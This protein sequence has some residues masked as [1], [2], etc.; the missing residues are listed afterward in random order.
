MIY[1]G[2]IIGG[3]FTLGITMFIRPAKH[4]SEKENRVLQQIPT[5][6]L[7]SFVQGQYQE[8]LEKG[9]DDQFPGRDGL[10]ATASIC[11]RMMGQKDIGDTYLGKDHYY[12]AKK[13]EDSIDMFRYMENLRYVEYVGSQRASKSTLLLVPDAGTILA[14]KLPA[15]APFY[16]AAALYR[17]AGS[18]CKQTT[19]VDIRQAMNEQKKSEQLYYRT[20]HHWTLAGAY[21]GYQQL[22]QPLHMVEN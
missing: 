2:L 9:A 7:N 5:F 1:F 20:D 11:K 17:A 19:F 10:T 6:S 13:T 3:L 12:L 18:V 14:D 21:V 4:F 8:K 15:Q 22:C 16:Q